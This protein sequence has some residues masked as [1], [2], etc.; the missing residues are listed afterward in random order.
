MVWILNL[1]DFYK[2]PSLIIF[3]KIQRFFRLG[4]FILFF[5]CVCQVPIKSRLTV[6]RPSA[7]QATNKKKRKDK[8][9]EDKETEK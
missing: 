9:T 6:G 5:V 8:E 1:W 7:K 3:A 2:I 4:K